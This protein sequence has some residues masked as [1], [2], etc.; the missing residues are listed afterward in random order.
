MSDK[1]EITRQQYL[2]KANPFGRNVSAHYAYKK[3]EK[4]VTAVYL[5]TNFVPETE[6]LRVRLREK[7][8]ML[9][10]DM[11]WLRHGFRAAG[12]ER[13]STI[14]AHLTE[15]V[16]LLEVANA[17]GYVSGMNLSVFQQEC[18]LLIEF[19]REHED[20]ESSESLSLSKHYFHIPQ[21]ASASRENAADVKDTKISIKDK[22][23]NR[24]QP[25]EGKSTTSKRE[26]RR[27]AIIAALGRQK[28]ASVRDVAQAVGGYSEKTI[29]RELVALMRE[30]V[31]KRE[32]ERRWST[33][34]LI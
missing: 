22:I 31:I 8:L 21:G 33:Y 14:I 6:P 10:T 23:K 4:I 3:T 12:P 11:L 1:K 5:V 24:L 29:Q 2:D 15:L 20:V 9:L 26:A 19:L 28:A 32:G 18:R 30:G 34:S 17:G 13:V 7:S 25:R 27:A 16:T